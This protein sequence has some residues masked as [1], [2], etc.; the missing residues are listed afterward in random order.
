MEWTDGQRHWTHLW[1]GLRPRPKK[2]LTEFS[3]ISYDGGPHDLTPTDGVRKRNA[4]HGR[5][6][7]FDLST[8]ERVAAQQKPASSPAERCTQKA[9]AV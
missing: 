3:S 2:G 5:V 1:F 4:G 8:F 6:P 7:Q 9:H